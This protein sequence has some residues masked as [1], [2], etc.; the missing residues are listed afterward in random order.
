MQLAGARRGAWHGSWPRQVRPGGRRP[1]LPRGRT[2]EEE[3]RGVL[4]ELSE[5]QGL[6]RKDKIFLDFYIG[7]PKTI[8][9]KVVENFKIYNFYVGQIF[10]RALV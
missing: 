6:K 10:I 4:Q 3:M 5:V 7:T 9:T 2:G 8:N 1:V